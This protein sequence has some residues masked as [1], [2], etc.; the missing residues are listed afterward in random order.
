MNSKPSILKYTKL[1]KKIV[2]ETILRDTRLM[3][4]V[5]FTVV[6]NFV[7]AYY[8]V[9]ATLAFSNLAN[10]FNTVKFFD[11]LKDFLRISMI[12]AI[13]DY[14]PS[15]VFTYY[16]Q[17]IWRRRFVISLREALHLNHRNFNLKTPG[18][19]QY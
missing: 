12:A 8:T 13:V 15:A 4:T 10:N 16:L 3:L 1:V 14:V 2:Q 7:A 11:I 17:V 19:I 5:I 6:L 18:E 9:M